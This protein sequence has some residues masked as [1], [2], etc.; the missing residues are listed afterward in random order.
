MSDDYSRA[1]QACF[2]ILVASI[3]SNV[4][5]EDEDLCVNQEEKA[6]VVDEI[7]NVL[8][9]HLDEEGIDYLNTALEK[10]EVEYNLQITTEEIIQS[11]DWNKNK[12]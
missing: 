2:D 9:E 12:E 8:E 11:L 10:F 6:V 3:I 5:E 4:V 1:R 7:F